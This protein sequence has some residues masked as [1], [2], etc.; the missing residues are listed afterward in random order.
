MYGAEYR[1][2]YRMEASPGNFHAKPKTSDDLD[3]F[4]YGDSRFWK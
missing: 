1:P 2:K 4:Q 3:E